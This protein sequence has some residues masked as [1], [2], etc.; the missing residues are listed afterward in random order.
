MSELVLTGIFDYKDITHAYST[1]Y[2]VVT[3]GGQKHYLNR[4]VEYVK[5]CD[6][7]SF[8]SLVT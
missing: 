5:E 1:Y 3:K 6:D 8:L 7:D 4:L 2:A